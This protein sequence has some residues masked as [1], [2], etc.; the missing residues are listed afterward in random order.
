MPVPQRV[1][2]LVGSVLWGELLGT[3]KMPVPQR[4]SFF[5]GGFLWGGLL[6]RPLS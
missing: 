2:F 6:A 5:V 4:V 1:N 3:G